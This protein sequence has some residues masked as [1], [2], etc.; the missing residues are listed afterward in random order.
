MKVNFESARTVTGRQ[1]FI[2]ALHSGTNSTPMVL[3][4]DSIAVCEYGVIFRTKNP[5]GVSAL[6]ATVVQNGNSYLMAGEV[7]FSFIRAERESEGWDSAV[8]AAKPVICNGER[9]DRVLVVDKD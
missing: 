5:T 4:I 8:L 3:T 2:Q 7:E 6:K 1:L 9:L